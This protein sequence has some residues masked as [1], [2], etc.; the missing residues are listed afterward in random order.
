MNDLRKNPLFALFASVQLALVLLTLLGSTAIIGTIVP[1]NADPALYVHRYGPAWAHFFQL[2][3]IDDMYNSWWFLGLLTLFC[4]NLVVCSADRL[5]TTLRFLRRDHLAITQDQLAS[6]PLQREQILLHSPKEEVARLRQRLHKLG[7]HPQ[8]RARDDGVLLFAEKMPWARLGVYVV[9]LS[10]LVILAGALLGSSGFARRVL[11]LP[12]FAYKGFV[13]LPEGE[14]TDQVRALRGNW[15][16]DLGFSLRLDRFDMALYDNGMPKN[17]R[18]LVTI[19]DQGKPVLQRALEVNR[20][21]KYRGVTFYQASYQPYPDYLIS[22]RKLPDKISSAGRIAPATEYLWPEAGI[23]YG[24]VNREGRGE[25]TQKVKLWLHDGQGEPSLLWLDTNRETRIDRPAGQFAVTIKPR[26]AS[27]LQVAKDPGVGLVY[28]GCL[29]MLAGLAV[30]FFCAH[31]RIF[32][33]VQPEGEGV[34]LLLAGEAHK[35]QTA[36]AATFAQLADELAQTDS[37]P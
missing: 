11:H 33:L 32:L 6:L 28:A 31:R 16:V 9:H 24:I 1:Q 5:P 12:G 10:I 36:F 3:D 8:E 26:Y 27:G 18:S 20:P 14:S 19:L 4:L 23:R 25:I 22:L 15:L 2:L 13:M 30:A 37:Q 34:R 29:L 7:W 35:N 21:L 17:Y